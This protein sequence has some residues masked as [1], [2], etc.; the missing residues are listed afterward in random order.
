ML[1]NDLLMVLNCINLKIFNKNLLLYS[2]RMANLR[3]ELVHS[4]Y[5]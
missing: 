4:I 5:S 1:W 3:L 2:D